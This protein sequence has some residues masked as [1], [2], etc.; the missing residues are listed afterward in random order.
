MNNRENLICIEIYRVIFLLTHTV[1]Y[2]NEKMLTCQPELQFFKLL[3]VRESMA[4]LACRPFFHF[5]VKSGG[6]GQ[7]I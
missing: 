4:G 5:G 2:R 1:Q 6:W 3:H 7:F